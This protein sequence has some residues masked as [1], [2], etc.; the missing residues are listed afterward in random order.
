MNLSLYFALLLGFGLGL[1]HATEADHLVAVTAIIVEQRSVLRSASIG[2]LWGIGHTFA[3]LLAGVIVILLNIEIPARAAQLLELAVALIIIFLGGRILYLL[4]RSSPRLHIH[5]HTHDGRTHAHMHFHDKQNA[6]AV[7]A[8]RSADRTHH[9]TVKSFSGG[10]PL[11]IGTIHGLAG[12]A[13]LTLLVLT[14]VVRGN[15][16]VMGIAYLGVFG[17]GSIAGMVI[18]T[19]VISLPLILVK[20]SERFARP[21]HFAVAILSIAFGV[22]YGWSLSR[23]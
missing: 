23:M 8:T 11:V 3:L 15:S 12:S 4:L 2:L 16:R 6:H 19:T 10:R 7:P 20:R 18:M 14:E 21:L 13:A 9:H 1:K 17:L 5:L 22:G